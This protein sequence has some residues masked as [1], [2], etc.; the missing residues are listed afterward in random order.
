MA[1]GWARGRPRP[2]APDVVSQGGRARCRGASLLETVL[3]LAV[4]ATLAG[5]AVPNV[6]RGRDALAIDGA[7]RY[8]ASRVWLARAEAARRGAAV[9]LVFDRVDDTYR[10][11]MVVDGNDNGIRKADIRR[12]VDVPLDEGYTLSAMFPGVRFA[13]SA[14]VASVGSSRPAGGRTDPIRL[15]A[16]DVLTVTPARYGHEWH[17]LSAKPDGQTVCAASSRAD[18]PGS[19]SDVR[20]LGRCLARAMTETRQRLHEGLPDRRHAPRRPWT[21]LSGLRG[22]RLRPGR[23]ATVIDWSPLGLM[24]ETPSRLQPGTRVTV[25]LF[26]ERTRIIAGGTVIRSAVSAITH[27]SG[28]QYRGAVRFDERVSFASLASSG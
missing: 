9:A 19:S 8:L 4:L 24:I 23:P 14:A 27:R 11:S 18:R 2:L 10:E 3:A 13:L 26:G 15:G 22:A 16:S 7:A 28:I 12:G 17:A 6:A 25:Q 5:L 20:H 21:A 1:H